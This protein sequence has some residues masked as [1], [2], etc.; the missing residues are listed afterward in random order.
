MAK[1]TDKMKTRARQ[2]RFNDG[3]SWDKLPEL[4]NKEFGTDVTRGNVRDYLKSTKEYKHKQMDKLDDLSDEERVKYNEE[5]EIIDDGNLYKSKRVLL[6]SQAEIKDKDYMLKAHE[7]DPKDFEVV[8]VKVKKWNVY[9]KLDGVQQLYSTMLSIKPRMTINEEDTLKHFIEQA[10]KYSPVQLRVI[11]QSGQNILLVNIVDLHGGQLSWH[12]ESGDNY[13]YKIVKKNFEYIINDVITKS[14]YKDY[15][16]VCFVVGNDLFNS[17]N[18]EGNTTKGTKQVNDVRPQKMFDKI[19]EM[20]IWGIDALRTG[21]PNSP[22]ETILVP[23]NHD[24]LVSYYLSKCIYAWFRKDT[25]VK[26]DISPKLHKGFAY[27]DTAILLTHGERELKNV[28]WVYKE[29]RPL[30]GKTKVTEIHAGH[31]H[32]LIVEEK[33]G[34]ITRNNPSPAMLD[35]WSYEQGYGSVSQAVTRVYSKRAL[36]FEIYSRV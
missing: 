33:N 27:G 2:L 11:K 14:P 19:E 9:S 18:Y 31:K 8:N 30:I 12:A 36:E 32:R 21:F 10:E 29:F 15:E 26:V 4:I 24:R 35:N 3:M 1:L 6:M 23:G 5:F 34:I 16:K 17:D 22:I 7:F 25:T 13:D 20:V 28:D